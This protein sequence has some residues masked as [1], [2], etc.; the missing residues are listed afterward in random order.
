VDLVAPAS[1][2]AD[3]TDT[4]LPGGSADTILCVDAFHFASSITAAADERARLLRPGGKLVITT[5]ELAGADP[6]HGHQARSDPDR[7]VDIEVDNRPA[8]SD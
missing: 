5:W 4:G 7:L 3:L 1:K 8:W 6:P 2:Q